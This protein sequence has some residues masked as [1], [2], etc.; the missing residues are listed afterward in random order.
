MPNTRV[1]HGRQRPLTTQYRLSEAAASRWLHALVGRFFW[2]FDV[3]SALNS[4]LLAM[5]S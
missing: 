4:K 2:H 3:H 1:S 5:R